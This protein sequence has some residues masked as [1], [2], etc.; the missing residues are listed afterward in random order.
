[1]NDYQAVREA[2]ERIC[3]LDSGTIESESFTLAA[4]A[5]PLAR[6][7]ESREERIKELVAKWR[8]SRTRLSK[9]P[10][11]SHDL[12]AWMTMDK[13]IDEL[14]SIL[15]GCDGTCPDGVYCPEHGRTHRS[16]RS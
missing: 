6:R 10:Q 16:G 5:L 7:I 3:A 13:C 8:A 1:M 4:N 15:K 11:S 2:L 9:K 14:E 12:T